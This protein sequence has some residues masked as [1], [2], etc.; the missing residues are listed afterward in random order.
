MRHALPDRAPPK[1]TMSIAFLPPP[2]GNLYQAALGVRW[3]R[4]PLPFALDHVNVWLL[5]DGERTVVVDTGMDN[6]ANREAW[7]HL[8][9]SHGGLAAG[10][11]IEVLVTHMHVDHVG[12]AGALVDRLGAQLHMTEGE[13]E[14]VR[15]AV[16]EASQALPP[17]ARHSFFRAAGWPDAAIA[18]PSLLQGGYLQSV[19]P[20]PHH[21]SRLRD[22][23]TVMAAST[24]WEVIAGSG[25][26]PE[27][28][29]LYSE[30]RRLFISGDQVL[31]RIS[32]NVSVTFHEPEANP[33][34]GWLDS[35]AMLRE[36]VADDVLVLPAHHLPFKGLHDRLDQL[37]AGQ[38]A[39]LDRLRDALSAP[40][41]IVDT[42]VPLFR[43]VIDHGVELELATG[44]AAACLNY[45]MHRGEAIKERGADGVD[46]YRLRE[47]SASPLDAG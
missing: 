14:S 42:F 5:E 8:L 22:G 2:V 30:E 33:M 1:E 15:R 39:A 35:I 47:G 29:C 19:S 38:H 41:R 11:R 34:Q 18:E 3:M 16:L 7:D 27:H 26:S 43:R 10:G 12:M 45:L 46:R 13:Y 21:Y 24:S 32:S 44:E 40:L 25:H 36:R 20:L 28:A 6:P 37:E 4:A 23:D 17:R 31:P 9:S